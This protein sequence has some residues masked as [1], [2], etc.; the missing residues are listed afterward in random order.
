MFP[1]ERSL[2]QRLAGKPFVLLGVNDDGDDPKLKE[3]NAKHQITWRSF[4]NARPQGPSL[5]DE[6]NVEGWPTLYLIDHTG[7]IRHKW[8]DSPGEKVLD[9][10]ID[11]LVDEAERSQKQP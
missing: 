10:A 9:E 6:W 7:V 11:K 3:K 4:K 8:L 2:V 5:S 1:H